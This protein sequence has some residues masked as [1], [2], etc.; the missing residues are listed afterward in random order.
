MLGYEFV[1]KPDLFNSTTLGRAAA[2]QIASGTKRS[3]TAKGPIGNMT[4]TNEPACVAKNIVPTQ[5]WESTYKNNVQTTTERDRIVS[6]RPTWSINRQ[7][8]SSTRGQY[9]TEF[10]DSFGK[11]GDDPRD[12]LPAGA[13]R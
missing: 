3:S 6:R 11:M 8:Y 9:L 13:T 1:H 4:I 2:A 5:H 10:T 7:A 12:I